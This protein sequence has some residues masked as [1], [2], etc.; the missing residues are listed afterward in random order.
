M[1]GIDNL[2]HPAFFQAETR[3]K[4]QGYTV[5]N[6]AAMDEELGLDP[7][8]GVMEPEFLKEAARRDLEAVIASDVLALL[9]NWEGS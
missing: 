8:A 1:T 3:L 4:E 5:I 2:N 6:P 7:H 9:P